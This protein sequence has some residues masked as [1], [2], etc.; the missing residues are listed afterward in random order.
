MRTATAKESVI[1]RFGIILIAVTLLALTVMLLMF[2]KT[3]QKAREIDL[4]EKS[5]ETCT[6]AILSL[7]NAS[8][9]LTTEVWAYA[10]SGDLSDMQNYWNEVEITRRRDKAI[11]TLLHQD[12]TVQEETH[13]MR[14]KAS[15]DSL[16]AGETWSMRLLAESYGVPESEMPQRVRNTRLQKNEEALTST[17]K[18]QKAQAYLFGADYA[19]SKA[20]IRTMVSAFNTDLSLRLDNATEEASAS[21]RSASRYSIITVIV[22]M[23]LI[24]ALIFI[25][26]KIVRQ[27]NTQLIN[28]LKDA[29]SASA[30]KTDFLS[31]MSHDMRTPLNGIIGMTYIAQEEENPPRTADCLNKIDSSSKFLLGLINDILDMAKAESKKIEL[32]PE[33]YYP[34][35]FSRYLQAVIQPLCREKNIDFQIDADLPEQFVPVFDKL[36]INQVIF[37]LLSNA[38]KFTP[39]GGIVT[40]RARFGAPDENGRLHVQFVISDNG[41]G[42]SEEFQKDLFQPFAQEGR[43]DASETRGTGL[44]LSIAKK[45][46]DLMGGTISVKS[47]IGSGTAFTVDMMIDSIPAQEQLPE[48]AA[49]NAESVDSILKGR[50]VLLCEDHPLNQEIAKTLLEKK[51]MY[52]E[53][54][55]NGQTGVE[56]FRSSIVGF[57]D[58]V[59]MDIRMPVL[60]GYE[61]AKQIR[62]LERSDAGTVPIVAMTADAFLDDVQKCFD[63]GMNAHIA[64]P[65]DPEKLYQTLSGILSAKP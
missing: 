19:D 31:R 14:A 61:A 11:E 42:M 6:A 27:K 41:I 28:T 12:L 44:G 8:D 37:N 34:E 39:E 23:V 65:I 59:L 50:H 64:K 1:P 10:I 30:A 36:R 51:K 56:L 21:N 16:I 53:I 22:L 46:L 5:R 3:A 43:V 62:A 35:E 17:E 25:Y 55:D 60:D 15:S 63:A 20:N 40:Y 7:S 49:D 47:G 48:K 58:L 52:V 54:A 13:V 57:Y 9:Y 45:M 24:A 32:H 4:M 18:R 29:Q 33:P 38:V 2:H 26:S